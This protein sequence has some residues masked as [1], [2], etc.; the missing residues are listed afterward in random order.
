M[1]PDDQ[2]NRLSPLPEY[3]QLAE[4]LRA[5]IE[6]GDWE[7]NT[8]IPSESQLIGAYGLARGTVRRAIRLL[9]E[10]GTLFVVSYRG[11]YVSPKEK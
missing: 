5:R 10:D 2:I 4:I 9:V 11:T 7:Q 3:R 6:R 1:G 8:P